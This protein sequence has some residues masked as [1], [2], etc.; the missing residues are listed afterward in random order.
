MT[1]RVTFTGAVTSIL[2]TTFAH[3][4]MSASSSTASRSSRN[5]RRRLPSDDSDG[6]SDVSS[7]FDS[8]DED[9]QGSHSDLDSEPEAAQEDVPVLSH[10]ARRKEKKKS[11]L[12]DD[13][14]VAHAGRSAA[15]AGGKNTVK[16]TA[17]LAPS[18]VPPRQNS[19]WV[20]NL[21]FKT[22]PQS[23][24]AFFDG[25]GDV[26]RVHMPMKMSAGGP[27][28]RGPKRE[29]RGLVPRHVHTSILSQESIY[30]LE[31]VLRMWTSLR[32]TPRRL[33]LRS[34]SSLSKE[35]VCS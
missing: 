6:S 3:A 31:L 2:R 22:T 35:G 30:L 29:N 7:D 28:G 9:S 17:E 32:R 16:N 25:V 11:L 1:D 12:I 33:R 5:K 4:A 18:K 14:D 26:T 21:A 34:R 19:V 15:Q 20:G 27:E 10:A 13:A 24:K 23:L 8:T